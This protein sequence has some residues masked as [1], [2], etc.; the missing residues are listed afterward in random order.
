MIRIKST[1]I[2]DYNLHLAN[3]LI[4]STTNSKQYWSILKAF[5]NGR[6][7]PIINHLLETDFK[8]VLPD[9]FNYI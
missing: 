1:R 2:D 5:Y 7:I 4:D 6:N 9:L 3:K 8:T